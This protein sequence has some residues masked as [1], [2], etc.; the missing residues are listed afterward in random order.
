MNARR[1]AV[2]RGTAAAAALTCLVAA[3]P[4]QASVRV[5]S[6]YALAS[7]LPEPGNDSLAGVSCP[8]AT[9]CMA[10]GQG[11]LSELWNGRTWRL[12]ATPDPRYGAALTAVSCADPTDCVALGN[13]YPQQFAEAW[14]GSRWRLLPLSDAPGVML[15]GISCVTPDSCV[16]VGQGPT[17]FAA[18]GATALLWNGATWRLLATAAPPG[19]A[20][21]AFS[22]VSCASATSCVAVGQDD[23]DRAPLAESWNGTAWTLLPSAT[24]MDSI[25]GVSCPE[26]GSC[27]VA[28]DVSDEPSADLWNGTSWQVLP[29]EPPIGFS[30]PVGGAFSSVA[31]LTVSDC[32]AVG[33]GGVFGRGPFTEYWNGAKWTMYPIGDL[34]GSRSCPG[35]PPSP[36]PA[37]RRASRSAAAA[38]AGTAMPNNGTAAAGSRA[39][40]SP[41]TR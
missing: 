7:V 20:S 34:T 10:V 33:N 8:A 25:T 3:A 21:S 9:M 41:S 36:A 11:V 4:A 23:A 28:G 35:C 39:R 32:M 15:S 1:A 16:A 40:P 19:T 2:L 17:T 12:L 22:A 14:N 30:G 37:R 31:C 29:V 5:S 26:A 6:R 18:Y 13:N 27:L 38:K 24:A